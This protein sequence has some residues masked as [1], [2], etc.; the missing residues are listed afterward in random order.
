MEREMH[1]TQNERGTHVA[2]DERWRSTA[3]TAQGT[4]D[5]W[6]R[7]AREQA[8]AAGERLYQQGARLSEYA[9]KNVTAYPAMALFVAGVV[10]YGI[11]YLIHSGTQ[12]G[13]DEYRAGLGYLANPDMKRRDRT[14]QSGEVVGREVPDESKERHTEIAV[15][16]GRTLSQ[17]PYR[18]C[19]VD[20]DRETA[21]AVF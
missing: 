20:P 18:Q 13:R 8:G 19:E 4:A 3:E 6:A 9:A 15:E 11:A 21:G 16:A 2:D 14:T 10:G 7:W 12:P 5:D 17:P 1:V